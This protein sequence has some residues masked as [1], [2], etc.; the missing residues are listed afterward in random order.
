MAN[1]IYPLVFEL[2]RKTLVWG[3][4]DWTVSAVSGS[5][6]VIANGIWAGT[7][8]DSLIDRFPD[9]ILGADVA[10]AYEGKM[11][12]LTKI[13]DAHQDLSI[14]VHPN[15]EM[16]RREHGKL[17]KSE[18][19][20]VLDA[21]PGAKLYAGFK[22]HITQ[23]EYSTMVTFGTITQVLAQHE[24]HKGDVFYLPAGRVHAICGGIK[25]AE[26]QQSS[27]VTYR[28]FDYNRPGIDGKPRELHTE[29]A[30]Q[31]IDFNVYPE[32][33]THHRQDFEKANELLNTPY[34]SV[35]VIETG[36]PFH[37]DMIK[38][39]SF[40]IVTCLEG[41]C[42]VRLRETG[43]GSE[44]QVTVPEHSSCLIPASVA[45]Y[46]LIPVQSN[47]KVLEAFINN[48]RSIGR[49]VIDFFHMA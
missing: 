32:Y 20:Y 25:L 43:H 26:V 14:Q 37:R 28:I 4:E 19:W 17:G 15:D 40:I 23:L 44:Q 49:Q 1:E 42:I 3:T 9:A 21:E 5:E 13:I 29:L 10:K 34:F 45:D 18:M 41:D 22:E 36:R 6:S 24:V 48:R 27:D 35:K 16:A 7:R 30:Q 38:Y 31:A 2:N 8:L 39:G 46:Y 47:A 11:P 33:K 12:L